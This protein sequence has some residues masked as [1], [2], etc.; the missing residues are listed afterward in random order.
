M[1]T[2]YTHGVFFKFQYCFSCSRFVRKPVHPMPVH[3][4]CK[5]VHLWMKDQDINMLNLHNFVLKFPQCCLFSLISKTKFNTYLIF[6]VA[7]RQTDFDSRR[8]DVRQTGCWVIL[9][10]SGVLKYPCQVP[11]IAFF[12]IKSC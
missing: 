9:I 4:D 8:T 11:F 7:V 5:L 10:K 2:S 1:I 3:L 6:D 12:C